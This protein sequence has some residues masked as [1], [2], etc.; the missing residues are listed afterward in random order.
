MD[1]SGSG[2][3]FCVL[4]LI[5]FC[6]PR[7]Q[8]EETSFIGSH[9]AAKGLAKSL[10]KILS[11]PRFLFS[12]SGLHAE[13]FGSHVR[14]PESARLTTKAMRIDLGAIREQRVL[15]Y[16]NIACFGGERAANGET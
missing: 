12:F 7:V 2:T 15:R 11:Q 14:T 8:T 5:I 6:Y 3:P 1:S 13:A 9:L 4:G 10:R 16:L